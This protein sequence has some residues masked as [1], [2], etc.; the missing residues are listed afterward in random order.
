MKRTTFILLGILSL[1]LIILS[2]NANGQAV[3]HG[4][5]QSADSYWAGNKFENP[6]DGASNTQN[7]PDILEQ[8]DNSPEARQSKKQQRFMLTR[9]LPGV[10][11]LALLIYFAVNLK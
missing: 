3:D 5:I 11:L 7:T 2:S 1:W 9:V 8:L 6:G 4:A 10:A